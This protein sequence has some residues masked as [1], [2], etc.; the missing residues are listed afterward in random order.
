M[1]GKDERVG[2]VTDCFVVEQLPVG[3][4][5]LEEHAKQVSAVGLDP[6]PRDDVPD[7]R[8]VAGMRGAEGVAGLAR[9]SEP[10]P[11]EIAVELLARG[12]DLAQDRVDVPRE[13][14]LRDDGQ[15][16]A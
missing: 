3:V 7:E 8:L 2:L 9:W 5:S 12:E 14:R 16:E 1:R 6:A 10:G 15:G 4:A 13:E 11:D